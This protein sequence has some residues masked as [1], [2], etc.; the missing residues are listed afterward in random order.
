MGNGKGLCDMLGSINVKVE[1][2]EDDDDFIDWDKD[3]YWG[4]MLW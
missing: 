4:S 3:L 2:V 1:E